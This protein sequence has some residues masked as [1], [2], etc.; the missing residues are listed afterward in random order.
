MLS[1]LMKTMLR[2]VLTEGRDPVAALPFQREIDYPESDG[3]PL[4]E[5]ERH[6]QVIVDLI[7]G[8]QQRYGETP[9]VY[10]GGN[11]FLYYEKGNRSAVV[12]PDVFVVKGVGK[13]SRN[14]YKVWEEGGRVPFLVIEVTSASTSDEDLVDKKGK[15]LRLGVEEY[16]LFDPLEEYLAPSMQ[17]F[18]L[19]NG[20]YVAIPPHE[21]GSL[22]STTT[23]LVLRREGQRLR[24]VDA[25]TGEP[26]LWVDEEKPLR[27]AAEARAA[28]EAEAR[29][30]AEARA[31]R[32]EEARRTAE[33]RAAQEAE[34]RQAA[35]ARAALEG[36]ARRR[37]A[38]AR[39]AAEAR[40]T[41]VEEEL[42]RLRR[43][44]ADRSRQR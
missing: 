12:A 5:T 22:E 1:S 27:R 20:R 13:E 4:A 19:R 17:G 15:Y 2:G 44:L 38:D 32:E 31:A 41:A 36:E 9:D 11:L 18:R 24:L 3:R 39:E 35:E 14:T 25:A 26:L 42:V 6:R 29:H 37:E 7:Y 30:A 10:V 34:A 21:D 16:V 33:S 23:G 43:E 28:Q 40:A 8:L